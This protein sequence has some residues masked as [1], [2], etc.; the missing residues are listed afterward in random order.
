MVT[1]PGMAPGFDGSA[2]I[3]NRNSRDRGLAE[4][5]TNHIHCD[6][7]ESDEV[8]AISAEEAATVVRSTPP[9][10]N[11]SEESSMYCIEEQQYP[12]SAPSVQVSPRKNFSSRA[13]LV[14][15]I[16]CFFITFLQ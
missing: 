4:S 9:R 5:I 14:L 1:C 15:Y 8:T 2:T 13:W 16:R 12:R 10:S 6:E 3:A 11:L 7:L